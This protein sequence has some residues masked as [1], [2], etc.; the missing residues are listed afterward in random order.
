VAVTEA[1]ALEL[2]ERGIHVALLI[3]DAGIQ[4][5]SGAR[6]GADSAAVAPAAPPILR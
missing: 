3:V 4:P 5:L 6:E 2:R 1:A